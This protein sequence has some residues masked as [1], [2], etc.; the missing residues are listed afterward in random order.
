[1]QVFRSEIKVGL[2]VLVSFIIFVIGIF[3]VSDIRSLWDNKKTLVLLFQYADGITR[4]SPVWYA[5]YEVGSVT[6]IRIAQGT[7]DKIAITI[8]IAP[9][10]RVKSDSHSEIRSLGMMGAK[11]IEISP[12]SPEAPLLQSGG[13]LEGSSPSSLSEIME[14]G[15]QVADHLMEL[16]VEA[17]N[18]VHEVR[19]QYEVKETISNANGLITQARQ[20]VARLDPIMTNMK[21]VTGDGGKELVALIKDVRDTNKD[22]QKRL[23]NIETGLTKTLDQAGRGLLEA[24]GTLKGM[25]SLLVANEDHFSSILAH[26]NETSRN[27]AALSD[28]IRAHPWKIVW[29]GDGAPETIP[30]GAELW[31]EK[32]RIGPYGK[33]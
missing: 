1:M 11:Y 19:T 13:M 17:K 31:R 32:G 30:A 10:A 3:I 6:D 25:R 22:L 20:Q 5:G 33:K 7:S 2:L 23:L 15:R 16:V 8:R 24:E 12:G 14:T 21:Q 9:E 29:K 26:L 18:L 27:M 28:D 4:G